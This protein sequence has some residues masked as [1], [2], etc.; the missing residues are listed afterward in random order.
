MAVITISKEFGTDPEKVASIAAKK[1]GY[2][3]IG[4]KMRAIFKYVAVLTGIFLLCAS[5]SKAESHP[6]AVGGV[7]PEFSLSVPKNDDHRKYLG[8]AGKTFLI[9]EIKAQVVIVQ[10]FSM[11]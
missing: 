6:P 5:F 10:I 8:V 7:L 4:K 1:L 11:Y 9:P 2:E 3:Y